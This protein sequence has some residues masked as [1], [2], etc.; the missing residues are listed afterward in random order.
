MKEIRVSTISSLAYLRPQYDDGI[1]RS[2]EMMALLVSRRVYVETE[3][4]NAGKLQKV[5]E[6]DNVDTA[7]FDVVL[8]GFRGAELVVKLDHELAIHHADL[9]DEE[10]STIG[11][12]ALF[13]PAHPVCSLSALDRYAQGAV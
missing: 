3:W 7:E 12:F 2:P 1:E 9:V 4:R 5:T 11:P 13:F 8:G 6:K 10:V